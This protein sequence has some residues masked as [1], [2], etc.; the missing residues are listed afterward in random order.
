MCSIV[1]NYLVVKFLLS[2]LDKQI[3]GILTRN[4]SLN[5]EWDKDLRLVMFME[6]RPFGG[7]FREKINAL[8][9]YF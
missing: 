1:S 2:S 7:I 3:I 8:I 5:W 6:N 9:T 4:G